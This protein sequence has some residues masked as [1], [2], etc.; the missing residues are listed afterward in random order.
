MNF[1]DFIKKYILKKD[2]MNES[3]S[4]KNFNCTIYPRDSKISS[5]K[6]F[7]N[8]DDGRM[9]DPIGVPFMFLC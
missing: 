8:I 2:I 4:Q 3:E 9:E 6:G 1:R 5:D 7:F